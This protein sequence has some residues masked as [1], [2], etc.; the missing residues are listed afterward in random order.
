MGEG[1]SSTGLPRLVY[2]NLHLWTV[3]ECIWRPFYQEDSKQTL[4]YRLAIGEKFILGEPI[5]CCSV[6]IQHLLATGLPSLTSTS[7]NIQCAGKRKSV[8]P[9]C[10]SAASVRSPDAGLFLLLEGTAKLFFL[11]SAKRNI[12]IFF[13]YFSNHIL[14]LWYGIS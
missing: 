6:F 5:G 1:L 7:L 14:K 10:N 12:L 3:S 8:K 11:P 9:P 13:C 4:Q 2:C